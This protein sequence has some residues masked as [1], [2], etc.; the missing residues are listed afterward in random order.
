MI[1]IQ[2]TVIRHRRCFYRHYIRNSPYLLEPMVFCLSLQW[3]VSSGLRTNVD[4]PELSDTTTT[5]GQPL[6]LVTIDLINAEKVPYQ[7]AENHL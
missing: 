5:S 1:S 3:L 2:V 7:L 6:S 4:P